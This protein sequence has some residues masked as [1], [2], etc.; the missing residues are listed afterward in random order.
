[1]IYGLLSRGYKPGGVNIEGNINDRKVFIV[2]QFT[3]SQKVAFLKIIIQDLKIFGV[4]K[5]LYKLN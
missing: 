1:M 2:L 4:V 5:F 3:P